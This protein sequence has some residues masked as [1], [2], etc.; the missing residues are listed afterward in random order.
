MSNLAPTT[1]A[2]PCASEP[3]K[4]TLQELPG[5]LT[6]LG[7]LAI[8]RLLPRS[9]RRLVGPV[10]LPRR[11]RSAE[12]RRRQ[13]DGR[14]AA[15]A[16]RPADRLVAARGRGRPPRQPRAR[17]HGGAR[18][19]QP[20]DGGTRHRARRGDACRERRPAAGRA[21]LGGAARRQ[22]R[23]R[24]VVRVAPRAAIGRAR[25]RPCDRD[26]RRAR[27]RALP[28]PRLL[29]DRRSRPRTRAGTLA[30]RP[31]RP[32]LRARARAA[33]GRVPA[34]GSRRSPSTRSTTWAAAAASCGSPRAPSPRA[35]CS[36]AARP[37]ARRS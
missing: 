34:R 3:E 8:R 36:S 18:R 35:C 2:E 17:G 29:A 12:L 4:P 31:D 14:G 32:R 13:A 23:R 33:R 19:A 7:G 5:R 6:D 24:S 22:P 15:P 25:R 27:G 11:L 26:H 30:R 9:Q 37:S 20:D 21:A 16:H 10:V 1:L 28:R